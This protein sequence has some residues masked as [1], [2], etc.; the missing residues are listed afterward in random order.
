MTA[1]SDAFEQLNARVSKLLHG[2]DA[3]VTWNASIPDPDDPTQ[4]RQ[5]DA[6]IEK[7]GLRTGVECRK[8]EGVLSVMWVE[9]LIGRKESLKLDSMIGV[10]VNGFT[11]LAQ[12]KAKLGTNDLH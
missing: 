3:T 1:E 7:A 4:P 10:A 5:I 11:P 9:E 6:L 12:I 8:R 2:A